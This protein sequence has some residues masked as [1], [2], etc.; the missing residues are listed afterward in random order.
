ML[1]FQLTNKYFQQILDLR[2]T[3]IG[4]AE[5]SCFSSTESLTHLYLECPPTLRISEINNINGQRAE[6]NHREA[7]R[8]MVRAQILGHPINEDRNIPQVQVSV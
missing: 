5:I 4:D 2:N 1:S 3:V 7:E 6:V 8:P